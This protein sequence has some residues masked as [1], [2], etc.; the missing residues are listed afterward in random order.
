MGPYPTRV[1]LKLVG[2]VETGD[3][4][5]FNPTR[6]RLKLMSIRSML[7]STLVLQP[8]EG[9]SETSDRDQSVPSSDQLQ[10]HKGFV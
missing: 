4:P 1:R 7:I 9:S 2:Y 6:V 10:P 8:H 3:E 5:R